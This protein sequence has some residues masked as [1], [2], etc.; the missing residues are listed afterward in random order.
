LEPDARAA[1]EPAAAKEPAARPDLVATNGDH[2]FTS[3]LTTCL[4]V[5]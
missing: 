5:P 2:T 3:I 4:A 1:P